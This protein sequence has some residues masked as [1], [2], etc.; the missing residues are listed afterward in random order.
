MIPHG[1]WDLFSILDPFDTSKN[2]D[3]FHHTAHFA[4]LTVV[5]HVGEL[6]KTGDKHTIGNLDL[7][8]E[9]LWTSMELHRLTKVLAHVNV[10]TSGTEILVALILV[11]HAFSFEI[12]DKVKDKL[13]S[14]KLSD[15]HVETF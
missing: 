12:M 3:L 9:Y 15:F 14:K 6:F 8:E 1:M 13:A 7:S 5:S 10:A 2:W 4:L 11:I